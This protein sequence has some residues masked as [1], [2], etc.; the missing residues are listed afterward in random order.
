MAPDIGRMLAEWGKGVRPILLRS[1]SRL[2]ERIGP[3]RG[4]DWILAKARGE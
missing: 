3:L 1:P 4:F 2:S